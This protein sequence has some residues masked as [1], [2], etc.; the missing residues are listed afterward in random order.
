MERILSIWAWMAIPDCTTQSRGSEAVIAVLR[1]HQVPHMRGIQQELSI[2]SN[3]AC[4]FLLN[5][6][7]FMKVRSADKQGAQNRSGQILDE[8]ARTSL[9]IRYVTKKTRY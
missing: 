5:L 6:F 7:H 1:A 2:Y 4:V 8:V 3:A 9:R